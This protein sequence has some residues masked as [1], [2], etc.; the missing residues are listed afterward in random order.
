M[1]DVTI[2]RSEILPNTSAPKP[3]EAQLVRGTKT[4]EEL[5]AEKP[6]A[7]AV[8]REAVLISGAPFNRSQKLPET[9][10]DT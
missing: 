8:G 4:A 6:L 5:Q 9:K 1:P 3:A 10:T 7:R 2:V